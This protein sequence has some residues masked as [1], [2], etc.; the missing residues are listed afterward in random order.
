[1]DERVLEE[2]RRFIERVGGVQGFYIEFRGEKL[3][4]GDEEYRE[5]MEEFAEVASQ[6]FYFIEEAFSVGDVKKR[7]RTVIADG[8]RGDVA[9]R[10]VGDDCL[11]IVF[12]K[13]VPIGTVMYEIKRLAERLEDILST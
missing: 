7:V 11:F 10:R 2:A 3:I 8:D 9:Y 6:V 5:K 12:F 1:M 4:L 13:D